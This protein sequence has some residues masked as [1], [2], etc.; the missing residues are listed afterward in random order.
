VSRARRAGD[1]GAL[2]F[3]PE[4]PTNDRRYLYTRF[5][6]VLGWS[7]KPGAHVRFD[8]REYAVD[9]RINDKGLRDVPRDYAPPPGA[10]RLLSLGDSFTE[11]PGVAEDV[12]RAR[13]LSG[14]LALC[15]GY[16]AARASPPRAPAR[17]QSALASAVNQATASHPSRE[18][19]AI[20]E[21]SHRPPAG[22]VYSH[23]RVG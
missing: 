2:R 15:S 9:M 18:S 12:R 23:N 22:A 4:R 21:G 14:P 10:L 16:R 13:G 17:S 20:N 1:R 11:A 8:L 6:P 7:K 3:V 5:D 19:L